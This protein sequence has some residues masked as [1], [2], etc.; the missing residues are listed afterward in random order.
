MK[1][2]LVLIVEDHTKQNKILCDI[3]ENSG[4]TAI[5]AFNGIEAFEQLRKYR[6]GLGF[7]SNKISC[8]LLD[9]N[10][11]GM[12]GEQFIKILRQ[13][14]HGKTFRKY[15]PI[16]IVSAFDEEEK[17]ELAA[18]SYYGIAAAYITKPYK[19]REITDIL[20]RIIQQNDSETLIEINREKIFDKSPKKQAD[21]QDALRRLEAYYK[22]DTDELALEYIHRLKEQINDDYNKCYYS[23]NYDSKRLDF[24]QKIKLLCEE[25][26][27][28]LS[29]E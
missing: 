19:K 28:T 13:E 5:S 21:E 1:K 8:I 29:K 15:I 9:W 2:E 10:M 23:G 16:V 26:H 24:L 11:P 12:S 22:G 27:N 6:R 7:L 3:V 20:N 25:E 4:Y 18:D 17:K 14:E